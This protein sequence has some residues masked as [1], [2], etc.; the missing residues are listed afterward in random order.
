[1]RT[2]LGE[3][4]MRLGRVVYG[5][6][7]GR[8]WLVIPDLFSHASFPSSLHSFS[9][10]DQYWVGIGPSPLA[11]IPNGLPFPMSRDVT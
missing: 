11:N 2:S 4:S 8:K 9:E 3:W 10:C 1:M 7:V 6:R 5:G